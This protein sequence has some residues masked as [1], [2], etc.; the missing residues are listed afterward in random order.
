M[1]R[2]VAIHLCAVP[3]VASVQFEDL[4]FYVLNVRLTENTGRSGREHTFTVCTIEIVHGGIGMSKSTMSI[5]LGRHST[6]WNRA[7]MA[8]LNSRRIWQAHI[9]GNG[10]PQDLQRNNP[11]I[12][13][14]GSKYTKG[15]SPIVSSL[16]RSPIRTISF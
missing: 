16:V 6:K 13:L 12:L 1:A 4:L 5:Q 2:D 8:V 9:A 7:L 14:Q 11:A 10:R 15:E 3:K